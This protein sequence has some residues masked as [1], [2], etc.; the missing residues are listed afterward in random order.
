MRT[1]LQWVSRSQALPSSSAAAPWSQLPAGLGPALPVSCGKTTLYPEPLDTGLVGTVS[2]LPTKI[3]FSQVFF[4]NEIKASGFNLRCPKDSMP[5]GSTR[6]KTSPCLNIC[7]R[8][9]PVSP[10]EHVPA[11]KHGKMGRVI[12]NVSGQHR[13]A[14]QRES[15]RKGCAASEF[16]CPTKSALT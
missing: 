14:L 13:K 6:E 10:E 16:S 5:S 9:L 1:T 3:K 4:Y 12:K 11:Q 2:L 7:K 8:N 15:R